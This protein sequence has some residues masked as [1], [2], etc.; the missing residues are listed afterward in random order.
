VEIDGQTYRWPGFQHVFNWPAAPG[1]KS[2]AVARR[3]STDF[4]AMAFE[5]RSG[6]WGVFRLF[7]DADPRELNDKTVQWRYSSVGQKEPMQYPVQLEIV[8]FPG[9]QDVFN[10]KFWE[11]LRCPSAAVQ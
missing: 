11:T 3:I 5:S 6:I 1:S 7:A 2:G 8:D 4:G 10:P 9:G